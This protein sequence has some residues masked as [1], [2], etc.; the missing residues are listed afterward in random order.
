[1]KY[2]TK[3]KTDDVSVLL[4]YSYNKYTNRQY[5]LC[6]LCNR[7]RKNVYYN[8][9]GKDVCVRIIKKQESTAYGKKKRKAW[10]SVRLA[11]LRGELAKP[12]KCSV[13]KGTEPR[14]EAHHED[15]DKPLQVIWLCSP[16]HR[17][18]DK[19]LRNP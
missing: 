9:V 7:E 4:K 10:T 2:C 13:C 19:Q 15:Y 5:Y 3:C 18:A 6:R 11:V 17:K 8:T 1:M 16:C 14:I 12:E